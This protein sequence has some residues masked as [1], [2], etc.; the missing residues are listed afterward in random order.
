MRAL[1][2][3]AVAAL[4]GSGCFR[5]SRA[6]DEL[7]DGDWMTRLGDLSHAPYI[8]ERVPQRVQVEW[9]IDFGRGLP[10]S[11]IIH[12]DLI[13]TAVSGGEVVTANAQTGR[14]YWTRRFNGPVA[15]QLLRVGSTVYFAT[16]HRNGTLYALDLHR[17]RRQWSR[18]IGSPAA[19]EPALA[20]DRIY[21]ATTRD[22]QAVNAAD[23][24]PVWRT[25]IS[26][27]PVQ[28]PIMLGDDLLVAVQDT[29]Y[30]IRRTNGEV[31]SRTA[32]AGEP[33]APM[34][35][36]GDTLVIA[37]QPGIVAAYVEGGTRELWRHSLSA[38][39]LAAPVLTDAGVFVL[40]RSAEL[41]QLGP[42]SARRIIALRGAAT[43]SLTMTAD[44][45][46]IGTLDGRLT[47]VRYD[48]TLVWQERFD[49]SIRAPAVVRSHGVFVGT[50]TGRLIKL[51]P[52]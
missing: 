48:G 11:P 12:G 8:G 23:G 18:R 10:V 24:V 26:G 47:F 4:I 33:S 15:G 42:A 35:V 25:R 36:R 27:L 17:G 32:L 5:V 39:V 41:L 34:A 22:I 14:R 29:L 43:E 9:D 28:P 37:M 38:P 20:D 50:L 52:E 51:I 44:G 40:T 21:F 16:Q 2:L 6:V 46:L 45:A 19:A 3:C 1:T 13:L 49:G 7:P 31:G 30:R